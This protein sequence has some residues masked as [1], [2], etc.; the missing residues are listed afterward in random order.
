MLGDAGAN[1]WKVVTPER[2][3]DSSGGAELITATIALKMAL[4]VNMLLEG[5]RIGGIPVRAPH[6]V[7]LLLDASA[8]IDG[9][10]CERVTK[11]TRWQ[12]SRKAMIHN[13]IEAGVIRL[14]KVDANANVADILTKSLTGQPFVRHRNTILGLSR[15]S[16]AT[17]AL[18]P[19][20]LRAAVAP[21]P[22]AA[23]APPDAA[24][25][26][27]LLLARGRIATGDL[28]YH[29]P[30][31]A[32]LVGLAGKAGGKGKGKGAP[33]DFVPFHLR[34]GAGK[35]K[36]KVVTTD[37]AGAYLYGKLTPGVPDL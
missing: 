5:L 24:L 33:R 20:S 28:N 14:V 25:Q 9:S 30:V 10:T 32:V 11:I 37:V 15:L 13:A 35:G 6:P 31:P 21:A 2:I 8:V 7:D 22:S 36:G 18:L 12:A 23:S 1:Y 4:G 26:T 34:S 27:K 19:E 17:L 16:A 3:S 29:G